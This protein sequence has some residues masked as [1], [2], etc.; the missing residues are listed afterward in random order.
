MPAIPAPHASRWTASVLVV[1]TMFGFGLGNWLSRLPAVRDH[2]GASTLE[3]SVLGLVLASG[4]V[5]GLVFAGRSVT[6][7]GP[8]RAMLLC[9]L[10]QAVC[11]PLAATLLWAGML[12]PGA[13]AIALFGL[14]FSTGDVAMNVSGAAAERALG[15][16]R[17][18][19]LHAGYSFGGV[20]AMGVGALAERLGVPVPLHLAAVFALIVVCVAGALVFVP[21]VEPEPHGLGAEGPGSEGS[22]ADGSGAES[23]GA[24]GRDARGTGTAPGAGSGYSPWRDRR[25][26][27]I[28][29]I[30]M[31]MSI[32]E[33][34][35][36]DWLPLALADHRGYSNATAALAL[37]VFFVSMMATRIAGAWLLARFG[38][39]RI[40]RGGAVLVA[41]SIVLL[42]ALPLTWMGVAAAALWGIGVALGFPIGISAA[43][44][45]PATAVR[46]VATVSAIAYAAFLV[47]PMLIGVLGEHF[48][49]LTAFLPLVL[50]LAFVCVAAGAARETGRWEAGGRANT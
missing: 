15:R 18:P 34:T 24:E 26:L 17:M 37:G 1:F 5:A 23:A 38:R 14:C 6:W 9:A 49:L 7:L 11:M 35:A 44:D 8:R 47:G 10:G 46:D 45:N 43:A 33:G 50:F 22:G 48:G 31:S 36:S 29:F 25:I 20:T 3:M 13:V 19:L 2:L 41:V 40:L 39:V 21:R 28:G 30:V 16:V 27:L 42:F 4:S 12:V 32:A